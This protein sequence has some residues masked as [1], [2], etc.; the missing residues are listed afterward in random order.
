MSAISCDWQKMAYSFVMKWIFPVVSVM[1]FAFAAAP[2]QSAED[3]ADTLE[4]ADDARVGAIVRVEYSTLKRIFSDDLR[5]AHSTGAV[6]DKAGYIDLIMSGRAKY[7]TYDYLERRFTFP[8]PGIALMSGKAH[9]KT[10]TEKVVNDAVLGYLAVW[11]NEGG[12]WRF[13]A[14]QSCKV[15]DPLPNS[16]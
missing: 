10:L 7:I 9:I 16:N 4:A 2:V 3:L 1:V 15:P 11:R 14:W 8:S 13:L 12:T 5:Y 6:D